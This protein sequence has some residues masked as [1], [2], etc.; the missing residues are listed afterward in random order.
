MSNH[1]AGITLMFIGIIMGCLLIASSIILPIVLAPFSILIG[2]AG[3]ILIYSHLA[4]IILS[5]FAVVA[6][7]DMT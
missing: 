6:G 4:G 7:R 3:F 5:V 1:D 2:E